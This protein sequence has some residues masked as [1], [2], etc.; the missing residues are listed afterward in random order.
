MVVGHCS[1]RIINDSIEP[2]F[3][4][5]KTASNSERDREVAPGALLHIQ[6][7]CGTLA[8]ALPSDQAV[9]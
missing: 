4:G 6:I 1:M 7:Y 2:A 5:P 9:L 3:A 8:H